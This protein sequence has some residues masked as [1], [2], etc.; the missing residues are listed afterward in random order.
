[1]CLFD[2]RKIIKENKS[3][4]MFKDDIPLTEEQRAK[5]KRLREQGDIDLAKIYLRQ[6]LEENYTDEF[7]QKLDQGLVEGMG[8]D[9]EED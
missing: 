6:C 4:K 5:L 1:M 3:M 7:K 9:L 2:K 8:I